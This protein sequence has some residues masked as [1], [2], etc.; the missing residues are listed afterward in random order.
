MVVVGFAIAII[1]LQFHRLECIVVNIDAP[2]EKI[3]NVEVTIAIDESRG[4]ARVAGTGI[5][6]GD[7]HSVGGGRISPGRKTDGRVPCGDGSVES[8]ENKRRRLIRCSR[9][10]GRVGVRDRPGGS[11][12]RKRLVV[13]I[14]LRN[15]NDKRLL[16]SGS[17]VKRGE[18]RSLIRDPPRTARASCEP[19]GIDELRIGCFGSPGYVGIE[20]DLRVVLCKN[21]R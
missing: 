16:G 8:R 7:G 20:V 19:P 14:R 4:K 15:R 2:L 5:A 9:K 12:G 17:V 1:T 21:G 11:A 18:S 13:R 3:R 6:A 10:V